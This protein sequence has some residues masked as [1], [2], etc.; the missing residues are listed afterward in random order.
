MMFKRRTSRGFGLFDGVIAL[1][2]LAFGLLALSRFGTRLTANANEAQQRM[3]A[4]ALSDELL[5]TMLIDS[6]NAACYT[7]PP[8]GACASAAATAR[9]TEWQTRALASL[10][11]ATSAAT[12][13][14]AATNQM[15]VTLTWTGKASTDT[16]SHQVIS[17]VRSN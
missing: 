2:I 16:H 11:G 9:A 3:L 15:A 14:N 1:A 8:A 17:D 13:L 6:G 12:A 10:P 5:N 4:S 7:L